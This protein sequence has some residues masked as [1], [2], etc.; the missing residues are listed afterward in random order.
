[1]ASHWSITTRRAVRIATLV[2]KRR[3]PGLD[4]YLHLVDACGDALCSAGLRPPPPPSPFALPSRLASCVSLAGAFQ[5]VVD[6]EPITTGGRVSGF[7]ASSRQ[8]QIAQQLQSPSLG[9]RCSG[10][11]DGRSQMPSSRGAAA[12]CGAL[13]LLCPELNADSI[14][15]GGAL[16]EGEVLMLPEA[17][18]EGEIPMATGDTSDELVRGAHATPQA[19]GTG[20]QQVT[21]SITG[22]HTCSWPHPLL[23]RSA[24]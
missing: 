16:F 1:M 18:L 24:E 12:G 20:Q 2:P 21:A 7:M 13:D 22:G 17:F 6:V 14:G 19:I 11:G 10:S 5:H 9:A 8:V 15:G 3:P 4:A 23:T